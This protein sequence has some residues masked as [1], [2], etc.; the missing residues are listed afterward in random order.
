MSTYVYMK[1]LESAPERYDAGIRRLSRGRI[2]AVYQRIAELAAEPGHRVL[3]LGCGTGGVTLACAK[4]GARVVGIDMD[5]GMLE[6]ARRKVQ[7]SAP[8][9]SIEF[10]RLGA[11]EIEDR[12]DPGSFDAI[13]SCL[14]FSELL[15]EERGYVLSVA[16]SRL[17][18]GGRLVVADE[19][20]PRTSLGRA[21]AKLFRLP[22]AVWTYLLTQRTT[23][24]VPELTKEVIAAGFTG[25]QEER[26]AGDDFAIVAARRAVP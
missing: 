17:K 18:P 2:D 21:R 15:V 9:P 23:R 4:R 11:M 26:L 20:A 22:S 24:P 8:A 16:R 12:F 19:V 3:D 10:L 6:V 1:L 7:A 5:A 13:V 25:V 14:L